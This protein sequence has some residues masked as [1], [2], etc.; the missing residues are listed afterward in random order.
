MPSIPK[1]FPAKILMIYVQF[2]FVEVVQM[3]LYTTFIFNVAKPFG[4]FLVLVIKSIICE[5]LAKS[6]TLS[7]SLHNVLF[8]DVLYF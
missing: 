5:I 8:L 6:I 4:T 7:Q 1:K 3:E 2:K